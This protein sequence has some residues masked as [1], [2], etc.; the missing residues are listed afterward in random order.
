MSH[1]D[2]GTCE[3]SQE[4]RPLN[5]TSC[6]SKTQQQLRSIGGPV[7]SYTFGSSQ[8]GSDLRDVSVFWSPGE[9]YQDSEEKAPLKHRSGQRLQMLLSSPVLAGG[10]LV[11]W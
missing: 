9:L 3:L 4:S 10:R 1:L 5:Q 6:Q 11:I 7:L 8:T 2:Q